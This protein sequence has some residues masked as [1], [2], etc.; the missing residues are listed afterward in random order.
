MR[1][2]DEPLEL[3]DVRHR[4]QHDRRQLRTHVR[5]RHVLFR[6]QLRVQ[7]LRRRVRPLHDGRQL[8]ELRQRVQRQRG[9]MCGHGGRVLVRVGVSVRSANEL[10]RQLRRPHERLEQLPDVRSRLHDERRQLSGCVR[11][12]RVHVRLRHRVHALQWR[13]R[14]AHDR[15]QL[16]TVWQRLQRKHAGV[17]RVGDIVFVRFGLS[18]RGPHDLRRQLR[19]HD[20]RRRQLHDLRPRLLHQG[21][22]RHRD[23]RQ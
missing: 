6:V 18:V 1:R 5:R 13:V 8:R 9:S 20:E 11:Q 22:Q 4:V 7:P 23:V 15:R 16:W 14:A 17:R 21:R 2:S 3:R 12:E 19:R 10:Q